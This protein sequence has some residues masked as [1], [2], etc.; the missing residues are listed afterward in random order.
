MDD[1]QWAMPQWIDCVRIARRLLRLSL[2]F[3]YRTKEELD[4]AL[5]V[6]PIS[7]WAEIIASELGVEIPE[8]QD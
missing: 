3:Q 2:S 4:S 6:A 1:E 7:T 8:E 5:A